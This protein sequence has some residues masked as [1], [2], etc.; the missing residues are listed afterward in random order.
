ML[1]R[2]DSIVAAAVLVV[3]ASAYELGDYIVGSG[4]SNS[5]EGP[6][7]GIT[8]ATLV[9]LPLALVLVEPYDTGGVALLVFAALACPFGQIVASAA[10]PGAAAP[11][12]RRC[13]AST[14]CWCWPS[15]GPPPPARLSPS[16]SG[17]RRRSPAHGRAPM[18]TRGL[19]RTRVRRAGQ[20]FARFSAANSQFTSL[21]SQV[22]M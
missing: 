14:R 7:A 17:R 16:P 10:L 2:A 1:V 13:G 11:T 6:L 12:R 9:A 21:S 22:S 3:V 15:S 19:R 4:A 18:A 20:D 8:T 5:I